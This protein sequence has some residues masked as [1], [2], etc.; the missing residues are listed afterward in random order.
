MAKQDL[1]RCERCGGSNNMP[2][3]IEVQTMINYNDINLGESGQDR[4]DLCRDC[5][6]SLAECVKNFMKERE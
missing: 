4:F 1:T 2:P 3:E 5:K 6:K